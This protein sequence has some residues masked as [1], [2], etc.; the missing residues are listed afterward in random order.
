MTYIKF[1]III[2]LSK[3]KGDEKMVNIGKIKK[4]ALVLFMAVSLIMLYYVIA[5]VVNI[6]AHGF[7]LYPTLVGVVGVGEASFSTVKAVLYFMDPLILISIQICALLLLLS[8][9]KEETPFSLKNVKLLRAIAILLLVL[10]PLK[11][12]AAR[13]PLVM[14]DGTFTSMVYLPSGSVLAVGIVV[15]CVSLVFK[16][17]ITL[18]KQ[19]DETL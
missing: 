10:E 1:Y 8:I 11:V 14:G 15:Y 12:I 3:K 17:G 9:K 6:A 16:Y 13:I 19:F 7:V 2:A 5:V 18:Q 4:S